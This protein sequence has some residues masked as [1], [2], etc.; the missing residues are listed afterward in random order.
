MT[1]PRKIL[2][3]EDAEALLKGYR[4]YFEPLGVTVVTATTMP[5]AITAFETNLH[6]DLVVCDGL[7][8]MI[9]G[10]SDMPIHKLTA[11]EKFVLWLRD[12]DYQGPILACSNTP[13]INARMLALGATHSSGK[14]LPTREAIIKILAAL[15]GG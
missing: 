3:V 12:K 15:P 10:G 7:F 2:I 9:A 13:E 4:A 11:G 5:E 14:G 6:V 1:A 8:P